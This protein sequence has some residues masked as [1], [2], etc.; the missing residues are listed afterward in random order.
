VSARSYLWYLGK[1]GPTDVETLAK[2]MQTT[3]SNA[4]VALRR[5]RARNPDVI[6]IDDHWQVVAAEQPA[7][8]PAQRPT[9][10]ATVI[11]ALHFGPCTILTLCAYTRQS[12]TTVIDRLHALQ[13]RGR[14]ECRG[15]NKAGNVEWALT[16]TNTQDSTT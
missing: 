10:G 12:N 3:K 13:R 4:R 7:Q 6:C 15:R 16:T 1:H 11:G 9:H 14:V 5:L 8:Q 2:A